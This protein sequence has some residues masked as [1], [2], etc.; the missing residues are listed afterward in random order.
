MLP[1]LGIIA[2]IAL[3]VGMVFVLSKVMPTMRN[4]VSRFVVVFLV[5]VPWNFVVNYFNVRL[6]GYHKMRWAGA[7]IIA[8][9]VAAFFSFFPPESAH[10]VR[11]K[12]HFE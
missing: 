2:R 7:L 9:L 10:L 1:V 4:G 12:Q 8:L 11:R 6:L 5:F 3:G